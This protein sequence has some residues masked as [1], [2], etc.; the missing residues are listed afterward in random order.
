[1]TDGRV[2]WFA[3]QN[4]KEGEQDPPGQAKTRLLQL[5]GGWHSPIESILEATEDSAILR[6]DI[7][8]RDPIKEWSKNRVTLLGD[9]AHPTTPNLGQGGCQ[10][11]EDALVLAACLA[12]TVSAVAA[13][14]QYQT[15]RAPRTREIVLAS[16]RIGGLAQVD[17]PILSYLR[18][19][20][21]KATP[22][23]LSNRQLNSV[24]SFEALTGQERGLFS[25]MR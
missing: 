6:N 4:A 16:R 12:T 25:S 8:D 5:F 23:S 21:V 15:R 10:A 18:N 14:R 19:L 7:Y 9:A 2:Y 22:K 17:S 24:V 20:I 1:M 3:T 13:L 11:I